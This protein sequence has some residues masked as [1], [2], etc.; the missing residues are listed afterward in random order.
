[1]G[2]FEITCAA[3]TPGVCAKRCGAS[4]RDHHPTIPMAPMHPSSVHLGATHT[5]SSNAGSCFPTLLKHY[6]TP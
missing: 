3:P 5:H 1:M 6:P 2:N 4:I